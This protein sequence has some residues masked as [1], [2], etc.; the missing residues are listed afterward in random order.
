VKRPGIL[1][2]SNINRQG[3]GPEGRPQ[4]SPNRRATPD[5][6]QVLPVDGTGRVHVE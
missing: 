4:T 6:G 3:W 5:V 2:R 1:W